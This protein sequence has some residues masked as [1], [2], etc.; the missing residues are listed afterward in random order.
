MYL[1]PKALR[2]I[3]KSHIVNLA[4]QER[5]PVVKIKLEIHDDRVHEVRRALEE[6]GIEI[7]EDGEYILSERMVY[8]QR[9]CVRDNDSGEKVFI[10]MDDILYI[11]SYGHQ[12]EV[13]TSDKTYLSSDPLYQLE[14]TLHPDLFVRISKSVIIAKKKVKEI[15]PSFSMK[16]IL[17]MVDNRKLEV[18]RSYYNNFRDAFRI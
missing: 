12:M 3:F 1:M 10:D 5:R 18:T 9:L 6:K 11:E 14:E 7:S 15:R 4:K 16:F 8:A 2:P 17:V 13:A